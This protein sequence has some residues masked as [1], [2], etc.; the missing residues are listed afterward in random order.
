VDTKKCFIIMPYGTKADANGN[1]IDFDNVYR[2]VF[3]EPVE[4]MGFQAVRSD[5]I[6]QAGS[7]HREMFAR[8][9]ADDLVI[10]DITTGNPNVFYEL[11]VRHALKPSVTILTKARGT[12]VPFNI[13]DQRIIEY[14]SSSGSFAEARSQI[15]AFIKAG[16]A[17]YEPDSPIFTILQDARKDWKRERITALEERSYRMRAEPGKQI[18]IITGDIR[19]WP[20]IDVW[21]NSENTNMQMAR[22]YDRSLSALIRYEGAKKDQNGEIIEDTIASELALSVGQRDSVT[23]GTIYVTGAGALTATL[24]VKRI[25]HAATS[26]GVPG[27]GYQVMQGIEQCVTNAL[28]R[29]DQLAGEKLQTVVFP[30]MGT[31]EGGGDVY[32][33]APKLIGAVVSYFISNPGSQVSRV[34]FSAWNMRDLEACQASL[35]ALAEVKQIEPT[36]N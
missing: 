36:P 8:I 12:V 31:G 7:I 33:I 15:R 14:P 34:Y 4:S 16:L 11:G 32:A 29:M 27:R 22:Y 18:S 6:T 35:S 21:V 23:P 3:I 28:R 20:G 2:E 26:S 17:S 25:F 5:E 9:A 30:M 13:Q 1:P 19:Q 10:V 24:G